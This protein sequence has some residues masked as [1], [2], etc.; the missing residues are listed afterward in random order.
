MP[1]YAHAARQI[2]EESR[3]KQ[4]IL[5]AAVAIFAEKGFHLATMKDVAEAA[6][7]SVGKIYLHFPSKE[8][9]YQELLTENFDRLVGE[10]EAAVTAGGS[11][12]ER[13]RL[14]VSAL[15]AFCERHPVF[16]R[17]FVNE[18][19]G[20]ELRI[21]SQLGQGILAKYQRLVG[22]LATI[23]SVGLRDREFRGGT[24]EELA[25]KLAGIIDAVLAA[26]VRRPSPRRFTEL[27]GVVLRLFFEAP[28]AGGPA[29][30]PKGVRGRKAKG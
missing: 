5:D 9:L 12:V 19:L 30:R 7:F 28:V 10:V 17:L 27:S 24:A 18:T 15:F 26:E 4:E 16:V 14:F 2:E 1:R 20:L 22:D 29:Q 23:F 3:H 21:G 6:R 11:S 13:I 25:L 8:S